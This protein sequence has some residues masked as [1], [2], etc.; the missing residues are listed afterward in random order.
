MFVGTGSVGTNGATGGVYVTHDSGGTWSRAG[1]GFSGLDVLSL[2][3]SPRYPTDPTLFAGTSK[4]LYVSH[5]AGATWQ[6]AQKLRDKEIAALILSPTY[7]ADGVVFAGGASGLYKSTDRGQ[8]WASIGTALPSPRVTALAAS[9]N[10]A[11]DHLLFVGTSNSLW[12][13][14]I[15]P[16]GPATPLPTSVIG[17]GF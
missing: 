12:S 15:A 10:Y 9:A 2:A 4:G 17:L 6:A 8:T 7:S 16:S 3:L 14:V 11:V 1:H 5:D 13:A